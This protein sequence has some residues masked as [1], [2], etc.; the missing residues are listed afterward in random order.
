VLGG[1]VGVVVSELDLVVID[2]RFRIARES[3][4]KSVGPHGMQL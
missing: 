1:G 3:M 4:F 2:V